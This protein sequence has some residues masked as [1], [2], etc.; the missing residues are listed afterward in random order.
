MGEP[1][2]NYERHQTIVE[3]ENLRSNVFEKLEHVPNDEIRCHC[4][5]AD[6]VALSYKEVTESGVLQLPPTPFDSLWR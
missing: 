3:E 2:E 4:Q 6:L 5:A 1:S